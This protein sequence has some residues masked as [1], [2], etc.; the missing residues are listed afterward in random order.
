M[1]DA[2]SASGFYTGTG[3]TQIWAAGWRFIELSPV[4]G[5]GFQ[6][7]RLVLGTHMHNAALHAL[8]QTGFLGAIPFIGAILWAWF[9]LIKTLRNI[10]RLP[11]AHKTLL[12]QVAGMLVFLSVRSLPE[13]TGAFFGI[14]WLLLGPLLLYLRLVNSGDAATEEGA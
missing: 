4:L 11:P 9:L 13:S 7:D 10:N 14:D 6:A 5:Y 12:V 8:I 3:R 2:P 1:Q